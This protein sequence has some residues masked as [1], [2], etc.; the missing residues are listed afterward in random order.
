LTGKWKSNPIDRFWEKVD[1]SAGPNEC[2][3][4][5]AC[6]MVKGYGQVWYGNKFTG[7]HRVSWEIENKTSI[8]EGLYVLHTCDNPKCVNPQHLFL[9]TAKDN[10]A[11]CQ[12]KGRANTA[13]G[14]K[15]GKAK[16]TEEQVKE[17][18]KLY[19]PGNGFSMQKLSE[20]YH[21]NSS[22]ICYIVHRKIWKGVEP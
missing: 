2:W 3:V 7:A 10:V 1:K 19:A 13:R 21:V 20:I 12:A 5:T 15:N 8:P 6:R 14:E 4:W 18:R 9:G 16:L 17:I 11:D 22:V